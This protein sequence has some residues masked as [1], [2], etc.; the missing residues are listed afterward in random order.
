MNDHLE[1][2]LRRALR[3]ADPGDDFTRRVMAQVQA[4]EA[5]QPAARKRAAPPILRWLPAALAASLLIAIIFQHEQS[6]ERIAAERAIEE[7]LRARDQLL[8]ALYVTS[9]KLDL[10]YQAVQNGTRQ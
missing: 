7:G 3:P 6:A 8:A 2:E 1:D 4:R 9:E 5:A 10:A